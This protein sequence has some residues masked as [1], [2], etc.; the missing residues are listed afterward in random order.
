MTPGILS[1]TLSA[2]SI[3]GSKGTTENSQTPPVPA[4]GIMRAALMLSADALGAATPPNRAEQPEVHST[5]N[6]AQLLRGVR[7]G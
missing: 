5:L 6:A 4:S 2:R 3:I 7:L 1:S